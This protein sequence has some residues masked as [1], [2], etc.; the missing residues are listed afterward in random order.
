MEI[1]QIIAMI[2]L[3][4]VLI[5]LSV[6]LVSKIIEITIV[7]DVFT[8][9]LATFVV[10]LHIIVIVASEIFLYQRWFA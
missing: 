4:M 3:G 5:L 6:Y 9:L 10:F 1:L 2:V 7:N 8:S